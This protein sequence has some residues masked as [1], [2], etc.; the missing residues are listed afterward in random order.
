MTVQHEYRAASQLTDEELN[1]LREFWQ[2]CEPRYDEI[3]A[4]IASD[5]RSH[6]ELGGLL[7][8]TD[9]TDLEPTRGLLARAI[10]DGDWAPYLARMA[11]A[12]VRCA[13]AGLDFTAWFSAGRAL[14]SRR[15]PSASGRFSST[16]SRTLA[17]THPTGAGSK[18]PP[19]PANMGSRCAWPITA[20]GSRPRRCRDLFG[21]FYRVQ[22]PTAARSPGPGSVSRSAGRSSARTTARS[23]PSPTD[24]ARARAFASPCRSRLRPDL[25]KADLTLGR[26]RPPSPPP[27]DARSVGQPDEACPS[28]GSPH[29]VA[30]SGRSASPTSPRPRATCNAG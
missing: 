18:S 24:Q 14:R 7:G 8:S 30:T 28:R 19:S 9:P 15:I 26:D 3:V 23:G 27:G 17:S 6:P 2:V 20:L 11:D 10:M 25:P 29:S 16:C 13:E 21:E 12:G 4:D 22:T 1:A 5:A